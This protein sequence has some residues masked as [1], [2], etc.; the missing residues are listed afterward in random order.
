[1]AYIVSYPVCITVQCSFSIVLIRAERPVYGYCLAHV[2]AAIGVNETS[3]YRQDFAYFVAD[4]RLK[5]HRL[6]ISGLNQLFAQPVVVP[7]NT[8][9]TGRINAEAESKPA[10]CLHRAAYVCAERHKSAVFGTQRGR[11]HACVGGIA[12]S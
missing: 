3:A 4:R 10:F 1:Y 2:E 6:H 11:L 5:V 8:Y 12:K 7:G 9:T